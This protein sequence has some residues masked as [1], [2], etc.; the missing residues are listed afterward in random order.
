AGGP[1]VKVN[2]GAIVPSLFESEMFGHVRGAFTD[3][4][5][6]RIGYFEQADR[7]T[8][9]LDE[10]AEI[11]RTSQIKLLRVLQDQSYQRVGDGE[12]RR[13][14]F[15]VVAAT[16]RDPERLVATGDFREGLYYPL[17]LLKPVTPP[18]RERAADI[19]LIAAHHLRQVRARYGL[20]E[21]E[22]AGDAVR[23]LSV[24]PW[25]GNVRELKHCVERAALMTARP[26]LVRADVE[27][28]ARVNEPFAR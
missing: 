26:L 24:Q 3:A 16:N 18:L 17:N 8:I 10:V 27:A 2:M 19:A 6:D 14:N 9:F 5:R 11:D 4:K 1:L 21:M 23:W 12:R 7:G 13:S 22:L 25:P 28:T 20:G 15:R